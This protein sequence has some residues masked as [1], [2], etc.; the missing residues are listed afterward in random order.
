MACTEGKTKRECSYWGGLVGWKRT[1]SHGGC[2]L[3]ERAVKKIKRLQGG[4]LQSLCYRLDAK[5]GGCGLS[6][7]HFSFVHDVDAGGEVF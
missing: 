3:H 5:M 4:A 6:Y 1:K 7:H 2:V